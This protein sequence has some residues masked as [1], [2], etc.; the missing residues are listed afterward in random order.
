[1][2]L[3]LAGCQLPPERGE[4]MRPLPEEI[5]PLPYAELLTRAR[6]QT[7][8]A[9]DA[10]VLDKWETIEDSARGLEQTARYMSRALEVPEKHKTSLSVVS[11][12]LAK[13]ATE[14]REAAR[15][16]DAEKVKVSMTQVISKVRELKID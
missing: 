11:G 9:T 3:A 13:I 8:A 10:Y 7:E 4:V 14:L 15:A 1:L 6:L 2:A 5:R 16:K 12:D